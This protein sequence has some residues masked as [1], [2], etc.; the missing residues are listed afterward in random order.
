[1]Y[2]IVVYGNFQGLIFDFRGLF[3]S[4]FF[5]HYGGAIAWRPL[6]NFPPD[7]DRENVPFSEEEKKQSSQDDI[8]I[9]TDF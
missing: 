3:F 4:C 8:T 1:M 6:C 5:L 7:F 9:I 2:D